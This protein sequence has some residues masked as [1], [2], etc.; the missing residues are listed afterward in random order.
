MLCVYNFQ[1]WLLPSLHS[2]VNTLYIRC[3]IHI[4]LASDSSSV[5]E[6]MCW[7][8]RVIVDHERMERWLSRLSLIRWSP[9]FFWL[10]GSPVHRTPHA[11]IMLIILMSSSVAMAA[12]VGGFIGGIQVTATIVGCLAAAVFYRSKRGL[13][14]MAKTR[15]ISWEL[16]GI[17]THTQTQCIYNA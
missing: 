3:C 10:W 7:L 13:T 12:T 2:Q 5:D 11:V 4:I 1:C 9:L 14:T 17:H 16:C 15:H 6:I 8:L